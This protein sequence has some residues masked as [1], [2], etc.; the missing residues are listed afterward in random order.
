MLS[1]KVVLLTLLGW[2][3]VCAAAEKPTIFIPWK[4]RHTEL[5]DL[6][7]EHF[8]KFYEVVD[9]NVSGREYTNPKPISGFGP[10]AA[11]YVQGRCVSGNVLVLF[12]LTVEGSVENAY[13]VKS[14]S[15]DLSEAALRS[16]SGSHFQPARLDGKTV[17][18]V[19]AAPYRFKCP[20]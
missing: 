13:A 4:A 19:V 14:P 8:G 17:P 5:D 1:H 3:A 2:L 16:I 7:H 9:V 12:I 10:P 18:I 6:A 11:V 20:P 15:V